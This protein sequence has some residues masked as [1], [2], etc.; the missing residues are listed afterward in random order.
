MADDDTT[1]ARSKNGPQVRKQRSGGWTARKKKRFLETLAATCNVRRA[2]A[3]VGMSDRSAYAERT[4][5][6]VF[7]EDWQTTLDSSR[8]VLQTMLIERSARGSRL[9]ADEATDDDTPFDDPASM[10]TALALTLLKQHAGGDTRWR[11]SRPP[12]YATRDETDTEILRRLKIL[13][14]RSG[15]ET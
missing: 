11:G 1:V 7:R 5:D 8:G 2:C 15:G 13:A 9:P 14:R 12:R 10:D 4:K 6:A 3:R